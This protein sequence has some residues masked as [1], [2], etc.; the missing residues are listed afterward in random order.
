MKLTISRV[1]VSVHP[2]RVI[3][4]HRF[5]AQTP[6]AHVD[7]RRARSKHSIFPGNHACRLAPYASGLGRANGLVC[8][9][10]S[11]EIYC[12]TSARALF[13]GAA[14]ERRPRRARSAAE[15]A[16]QRWLREEQA[17][18]AGAEHQPGTVHEKRRRASPPSCTDARAARP[19][20]PRPAPPSPT[21][22]HRAPPRPPGPGPPR[23][24]LPHPSP[25]RPGPPHP[26]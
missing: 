9:V 1:H 8:P 15:G 19:A 20:P 6:G 13:V 12:K 24:T 7:S 10:G 4:I 22:P 2:S 17:C 18:A 11:I 21:P 14:A 26:G 3:K 5:A 23:P 25:P 16:L